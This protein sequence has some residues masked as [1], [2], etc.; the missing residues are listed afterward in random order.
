MCWAK[1]TKLKTFHLE[2]F[3]GWIPQISCLVD[4]AYWHF[5]Q[6]WDVVWILHIHIPYTWLGIRLSSQTAKNIQNMKKVFIVSK[7]PITAT[8][9]ELNQCATRSLFPEPAIPGNYRKGKILLRDS[10][11]TH[12]FCWW[13][14]SP[15]TMNCLTLSLK[16]TSLGEL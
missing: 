6:A 1:F 16:R 2:N 15:K 11:W 10:S 3:V 7:H 12:E 4:R 5:I 13:T 9:N 14:I 8:I